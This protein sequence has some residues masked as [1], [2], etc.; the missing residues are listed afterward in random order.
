M[1]SYD[2][3]IVGA[4]P[5]GCVMAERLANSGSE[6][7]VIDRRPHVA[8]NCYDSADQD[9]LLLHRY[10]PHYFRTSNESTLQYLSR[11]TEWIPGRYVVRSRI[12]TKL[13]PIPINLD[14]L[15]RFFGRSFDAESAKAFLAAKAVPIA[16]P[17]TAEQFCLSRVGPELYAAFYRDYTIKQWG[18]GADKL[19]ATVCGRIPIRFNRDNRYVDATYQVM[20]RDGYTELFGR[21]LV[22]PRIHVELNHPYDHVTDRPRIGTVYCGPVDQY[23][24]E[25]LGPLPWRSLRFRYESPDREFVQ[26]CVQINYPDLTHPYTRSVEIKHVTGQHHPKTVVAYEYPEAVGEPYYPIPSPESEQLAARYALLAEVET[27]ERNVHFLGRLA[28]YRY[29]DMNTVIE[30]ALALASRLTA[31]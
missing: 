8:G 23:F 7:L 26:P 27:R 5:S 19:A 11:F 1:S 25:R 20:P 18:V 2:W 6:V 31:P 9:G 14:T 16:D 3:L 29:L 22:H 4:G 17:K 12:G 28:T 13:L 21:M 24:G 10:G 15:E 30:N